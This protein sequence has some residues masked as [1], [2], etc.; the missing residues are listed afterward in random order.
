[1]L[2]DAENDELAAL[3]KDQSSLI[4]VNHDVVICGVP[5][6]PFHCK[7]YSTADGLRLAVQGTISVLTHM[8]SEGAKTM[9][10]Q[11][12]DRVLSLRRDMWPGEEL[13]EW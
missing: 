6:F 9:R 2:F 5:G 3:C 12:V 10:S 13:E 7:A 1:L 8:I 11:I 4:T